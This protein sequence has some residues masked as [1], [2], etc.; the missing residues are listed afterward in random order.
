MRWSA[1]P[2]GE[3]IV[4]LTEDVVGV[5]TLSGDPPVPLVRCRDCGKTDEC[6]DGL[7][8]KRFGCFHHLTPPDGYCHEGVRR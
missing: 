6:P 7:V 3:H 1:K 4:E 8:C 5:R 2:A